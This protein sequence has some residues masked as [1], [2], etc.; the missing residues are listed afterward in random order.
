MKLEIPVGEQG[1]L[2]RKEKRLDYKKRVSS[3][4]HSSILT[5]HISMTPGL[6]VKITF[7]GNKNCFT[8]RCQLQFLSICKK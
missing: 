8:T 3:M 2:G 1:S 6:P 4:V 5:A 7:N